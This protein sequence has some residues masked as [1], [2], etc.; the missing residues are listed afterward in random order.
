MASHGDH[1]ALRTSC[2][3]ESVLVMQDQWFHSGS[4]GGANASDYIENDQTC[5]RNATRFHTLQIELAL[6]YMIYK[7]CNVLPPSRVHIAA[8]AQTPPSLFL[9]ADCH[10]LRFLSR[11]TGG[12]RGC[13]SNLVRV[14]SASLVFSTAHLLIL[15]MTSKSPFKS[16]SMQFIWCNASMEGLP[17]LVPSVR[18]DSRHRPVGQ[19]HFCG[20]SPLFLVF[21]ARSSKRWENYRSF[22]TPVD[23][24]NP[25]SSTSIS[26]PISYILYFSKWT[27]FAAHLL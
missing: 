13:H 14:S 21:F 16:R 17:E 27:H 15:L 22:S 12:I 3:T 26:I 4:D 25:G 23:R 24:G 1:C 18:L 2:A 8:H 6:R 7:T 20:P 11:H 9:S 10:R 5:L 19:T